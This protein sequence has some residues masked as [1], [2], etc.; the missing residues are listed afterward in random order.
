MYA[1]PNILKPRP[2]LS[3]IDIALEQVRQPTMHTSTLFTL[4]LSI[5]FRMFD[6][7]W[8]KMPPATNVTPMKKP[9]SRRV[10]WPLL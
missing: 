2:V 10:S 4:F 3:N 6:T 8:D 7:M 9:M 5:F 1:F